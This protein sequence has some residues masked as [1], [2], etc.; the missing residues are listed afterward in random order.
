MRR[1]VKALILSPLLLVAGPVAADEVFLL[2]GDRLTGKIV[3]ATGGKLI[4]NTDAAGD[5]TID[6]AKVKTFSA[7]AP[8]QLQLGE[9][10]RRGVA[11]RGGHGGRSSG[12]DPSG[13]TGAAA[14]DQGHHGHQSPA[15]G[16]A[17]RLRAQR[18]VDHAG[19]PRPSSSA[20][21]RARPSAGRRSTLAGRRVRL[22]AADGSELRRV[23]STT[24]DYGAGF[25]KYDHFFT[26][27]FYGYAGLQGRAR[28]RGRA[29]VPHHARSWRGLPVV[30]EPRV[31]PL[32][33][34]GSVLGPRAVRGF[35][36]P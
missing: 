25:I 7:E 24:V 10:D 8:V 14:V 23:T 6:L 4:L 35:G 2:N 13:D 34:G 21:P 20:S 30:R 29:H 18:A 17:R 5:I 31:Q 9:Q 22:W 32:H 28:R 27:K 11:R 19:T 12:R 3:S 26:K 1:I 16:M 15:S 33:R 36:E